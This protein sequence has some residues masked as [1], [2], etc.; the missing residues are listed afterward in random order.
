MRTVRT[1]VLLA[2][3]LGVLAGCSDDFRTP[4]EALR[5]GGTLPNAV[6]NEVYDAPLTATGGLRPYIFALD[7]N[8]ELPPGLKLTNGRIEGTPTELGTSTF[9]ITV[10][11]GNLSQTFEKY[12][13]RVTELPPPH[14]Q[15]GPPNTEVR[16]TVTLHVRVAEAR[17]LQGVKSVVRFDPNLFALESGSVN[18]R[19]GLVWH[20]EHEPGVVQFDYARLGKPLFGSATVYS[21]TLQVLPE[22]AT[23][24]LRSENEFA[25][26]ASGGAEFTA[27]TSSERE[28]RAYRPPKEP[29]E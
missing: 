23:L 3:V 18:A 12:T 10:S 21:F 20:T 14:I 13:L 16:G 17:G 25:T 9:T 28:G 15:F 1:F 5:L 19:S 27:H 6:I 8:S 4:G 24:E 26:V 2:L 7:A 11:D 22:V 29:T